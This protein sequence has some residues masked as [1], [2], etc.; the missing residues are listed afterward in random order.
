MTKGITPKICWFCLVLIN[1]VLLNLLRVW[2]FGTTLGRNLSRKYEFP[3]R[4]GRSLRALERSRDQEIKSREVE[5]GSHSR[6]DC[7]ASELFLGS[8]FL[9]TV[10]VPLFRTAVETAVSGVHKLLVTGGVPT[11]L[12]LLFWRRLAVSSV[13]TGRSA[14]TR[15]FNQEYKFSAGKGLRITLQLSEAELKA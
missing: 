5:P 2:I 9:D 7:L 15:N 6:V 12:T 8:C 1:S 13:F 11:P 14:R 3:G 10:F 4:D